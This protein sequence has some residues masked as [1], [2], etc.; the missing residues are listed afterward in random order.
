MEYR[1]PE[2][3]VLHN[4]QRRRRLK[5][6]YWNGIYAKEPFYDRDGEELFRAWRDRYDTGKF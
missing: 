3:V 2:M 5:L 4:G 1:K 6:L